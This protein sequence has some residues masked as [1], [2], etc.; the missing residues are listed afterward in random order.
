M[1][2]IFNG[3]KESLETLIA[4]A[5]RKALGGELRQIVAPEVPPKVLSPA[6]VLVAVCCS[7]CLNESVQHELNIIAESQIKIQIEEADEWDDSVDLSSL[8]ATP[9]IILF[10]ALSENIIAKAANGIFDEP[11][12]KLLLEVIRQSKP[13]YAIAPETDIDLRK[14][15]PVLFRLSQQYRQKLAQFGLRWITQ[16]DISKVL[17]SALP[18]S[19]FKDITTANHNTQKKLLTAPE[20]EQAARNGQHK[21]QLPYR[22]IIT[23]LARDRAKELN[24]VIKLKG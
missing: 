14:N 1:D 6:P 16:K 4:Q 20:I 8:I 7:D 12:S 24:V 9:Q 2:Y 21:L 22:C 13:F 10:P 11:L 3:T 23:P 5:V 15:S 17:L 19:T 18:K